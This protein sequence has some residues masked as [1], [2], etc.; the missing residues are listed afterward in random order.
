MQ[1]GIIQEDGN[2]PNIALMKLASY[3]ESIGDDVGWWNGPLFPCDKVYAS[4]IFKFTD[5]D[6]PDYVV[7]GGTGYDIE[8]KLPGYVD[9]L[10]HA[11][12]WFLYPDYLNHIG[13]SERGCRLKCSFCVVPQKEGKPKK[14]ADISDLLTNPKGGDRLVLLDDDFL[15][16]PN[17]EEV[18]EE[19]A[20]RNIKVCFSQGLNIRTITEKQAQLLAKV[21]FWSINYTSRQITFAWDQPKDS[22]LIERGFKRCV[23]AGIK[24]YKMQFF[25]L[26]GY[27]S[28]KEEDR[29]RVET[30]RS[31]DAD[32][33]VMAYDRLDYYQRR[34]QRWVNRREIFNTVNFEDYK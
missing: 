13:F 32:P 18:F 33:F 17:C 15:G 2:L 34:F 5:T 3:H 21:D 24:P 1:I 8:T 14:V 31:W 23:D 22:K 4:R 20:D 19:L 7:R 28:T 10:D 27:D 11:G 26:I 25:V 16:H 12:G 29:D 6:L 30:I 9:I